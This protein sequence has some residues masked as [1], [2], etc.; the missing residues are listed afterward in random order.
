MTRLI[1]TV[2]ELRAL[3]RALGLRLPRF[4][5][6]DDSAELRIDVVALR[7]LAARDLVELT[8]PPAVGAGPAG[9]LLLS[10]H[11][12]GYLARCATSSLLAELVLEYAGE[13]RHCA[14]LGDAPSSGGDAGAH[15]RP[16]AH[17]SSGGDAG[18]HPSPEPDTA[19]GLVMTRQLGGLVSLVPDEL[20]VPE[21][22]ARLCGVDRLSGV[23]TG[24]GFTV[25]AEAHAEA[26]ELALAGDPSGAV[27][28][29][30]GAGAPRDAAQGWIEAVRRRRGAF[31]VT[32]HDGGGAGELRWL[33][34]PNGTAWRVE[35]AD[36]GRVGGGGWEDEEPRPMSVITPV[37]GSVLRGALAALFTKPEVPVP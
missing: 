32:V 37:P 36:G 35:V 15:P 23:P 9:N 26:D 4:V 30:G 7:G 1:L 16:G 28:V 8:E 21:S 6:D 20:P 33:V 3:R 31:A 13:L 22:V 17:P 25:D 2:D 19:R 24:K 10:E 27:D 29:L 12:A 18:A 5:T 14:V 11:L 34:G